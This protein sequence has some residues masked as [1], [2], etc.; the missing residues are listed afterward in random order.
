MRTVLLVI[1]LF[2]LSA[3]VPVLASESG[4]NDQEKNVF[5]GTFADALWTV[6]AFVALLVVLRKFA[7]KPMLEKLNER[8]QH[9]QQQI[10]A[11]NDA[12]RQAEKLLD[13]YKLQG[14]KIIQDAT[15]YAQQR[16]EELLERARQEVLATKRKAQD[17]I[18]YARVAA[19]DKL[20]ADATD[21]VSAL[22]QEVL[23]RTVTTEDNSRLTQDA[24]QQIKQQPVGDKQI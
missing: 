14:T 24:I 8:E 16:Q 17:D 13:E 5:S 15:D 4:Q 9:I 10:D 3:A 18:E 7:W 1:I 6:I 19:L 12:R 21:I 20:W 11:A 22:S 2:A 23:G